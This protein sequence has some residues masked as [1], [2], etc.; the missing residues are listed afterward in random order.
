MFAT[1]NL[2]MYQTAAFAVAMLTLGKYLTKKI[3][4][5]SKF[6]IPAPVTGGLVFA[7]IA[8]VCHSLGIIE[9]SFDKTIGDMSMVFFFSSV[10]FQANLKLL[11]KG[12]ASLGIMLFLLVVMIFGQNIIAVA[13]AKVIGV[14]PFIGLCAGSIPMVGGH[15][16]SVAFGPLFEGFGVEGATTLCTAAA[17]FGLI[18]GSLMGG[19]IGRN[20]IERKNLLQTAVPE[21]SEEQIPPEK[22]RIAQV[23]RYTNVVMTMIIAV[24][25]GSCV[26]WL[27]TKSGLTFPLYIGALLVGAVIRNISE[28]TGLFA[29]N[30]RGIDR[31]GELCLYMFLGIAMIT[32]KIWQLV[33]LALPLIILLTGQTLFMFLFTRFLV[34]RAMGRNYDAAVISAGMCGFGMGAMPN[35][36]ANMQAI[37]GRY[38]HS[39]KAYLLIPVVGSIFADFFNSLIITFFINVLK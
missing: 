30:M 36:M 33:G 14:T 22:G 1:I 24:G 20:L 38:A 31:F 10:G 3:S 35:A 21:E 23:R 7:V 28:F 19:P 2:D 15:G 13:L 26:S 11:K 12:G 34:F 25:I 5:L 29:L 9:F 8:C 6:C 17:T 32:L 39:A 37:C 4:F 16:T 27:L 18:A